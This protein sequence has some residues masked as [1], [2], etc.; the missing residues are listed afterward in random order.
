MTYEPWL[1]GMWITGGR[2]RSISPTWTAW[3]PTWSTSTGSNTPSYGN[4][5]LNCAYAVSATT[6]FWRMDIIFGSTTNFGG[7]AGSDNWQFSL[8]VTA[9]STFAS[10]G[11]LELTLSGGGRIYARGRALSTS[12]MGLEIATG[13]VDAT[14]VTSNGLVDAVSP[15]TWASGHTIRGT[16]QYEAAA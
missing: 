2:L 13:R 8:P 1:A 16:G 6:V 7:G 5:T 3:T 12:Q 14:A 11:H 9:A 15:W 10:I 4:A